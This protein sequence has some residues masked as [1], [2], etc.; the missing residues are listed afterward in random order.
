MKGLKAMHRQSR[1]GTGEWIAAV[2]L[3][4]TGILVGCGAP[5]G[6]TGALQQ[7]DPTASDSGIAGCRAATGEATFPVFLVD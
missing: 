5:G 2:A 1:V 6:K 7:T 4:S 3:L